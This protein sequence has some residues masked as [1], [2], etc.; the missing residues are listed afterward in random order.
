MKRP[1]LKSNLIY[2]HISIRD[3]K[4]VYN[5]YFK[6]YS[7]S[8]NINTITRYLKKKHS[9]NSIFNKVAKKRIREEIEIDIAILRNIDI[10]LKVEEER[11]KKLI[12]IN[13][14]KDTLKYLYL[15]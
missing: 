6:F 12:N 2:E 10:N 8:N 4:F 11:R 1:R 15:Q 7:I 3:N 5:R 14:N 13:L 9:I